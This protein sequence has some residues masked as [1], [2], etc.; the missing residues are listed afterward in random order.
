MPSIVTRHSKQIPI[1]HNG[2][3]ASPVTERRN[4]VTPLRS[5]AAETMLPGGTVTETPLTVMLTTSRILRHETQIPRTK[6]SSSKSGIR[7]LEFKILTHPSLMRYGARPITA[8]RFA[9]TSPRRFSADDPSFPAPLDLGAAIQIP[10]R[11]DPFEPRQQTRRA[12]ATGSRVSPTAKVYSKTC[13]VTRLVLPTL[14]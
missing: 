2:P 7:D 6:I 4:E 12:N 11:T 13:T 5:T 9:K 1:P 8:T 3:R 10:S 14:T